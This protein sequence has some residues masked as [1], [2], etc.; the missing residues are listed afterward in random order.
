[1]SATPDLRARVQAIID[2]PGANLAGFAAMTRFSY[3][4]L[5]Q[6]LSG[7]RNGVRIASEIEPLVVSIERGERT[8]ET[9][10]TLGRAVADDSVDVPDVADSFVPES[11]PVNY[12]PAAPFPFFPL[13]ITAKI[14]KI[15]GFVYQQKSMGLLCADFGSGKTRAVEAWKLAHPK[16]EVCALEFEPFRTANRTAFISWFAE[17]LGVHCPGR[18]G[19]HLF[20]AVVAHLRANPTLLIFD[21][22]EAVGDSVLQVIRAIHDRTWRAG[23]G[24]LLLAQLVLWERLANSRGREVGALTS[25]LRPVVLLSG[26]MRAEMEEIL[27]REKIAIDQKAAEAL[28]LGVQGSTR[29]LVNVIGMLQATRRG[30]PVTEDVVRNVLGYLHGPAAKKRGGRKS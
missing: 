6:W 4:G 12:A 11:F 24:V 29:S 18:T 28:W 26:V 25:R 22:C 13:T 21:Q 30:K 3:G 7:L 16:V 17:N 1:M 23:V 19:P 14:G 2:K 27:R 15:I 5:Y 9:A 8:I 20:D 10:F